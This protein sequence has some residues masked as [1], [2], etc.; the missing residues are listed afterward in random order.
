LEE[1]PP[2][3]IFIFATTEPH[4]I[5]STIHSRCQRFDFRRIAF[6]E[7]HDRLKRIASEEGIKI[8]EEALFSLTREAEGSLRDAQ[9]LLDQVIAFAG[10]EGINEKAVAGALGLMDRSVL[11]ELTEAV[12]KK[13]GKKCLN[14]VE[15]IYNFGY[16]LKK[17]A[18]DLLEQVRDLTVLKVTGEGGGAGLLELPESE[19]NRLE[20]LSGLIGLDRLQ[21]IFTVLTRGYEEVARSTSPRFSF[22]MA[23]LRAVHIEDVE[24]VPE[25]I[26]RLEL[27]K[28]KVGA[29]EGHGARSARTAHV[30]EGEGGKGAET[31]AVAEG[32]VRKSGPAEGRSKDAGRARKAG[33]EEGVGVEGP[34]SSEGPGTSTSGFMEHIR[35][36]NP[37][38]FKSLES[39]AVSLSPTGLT[40]NVI[41]EPGFL[42]VKKDLLESIASEYFKKRVPVK[43]KKEGAVRKESEG[44]APP[45]PDDTLLNDAKRIFGG[46][47]VEDRRRTN[48]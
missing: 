17:A 44:A 47:V 38:L 35:Q 24:S 18:A 14:I 21:M 19:A 8:E 15:K 26:S 30:A 27:L 29:A 13:D 5:P 22:E 28:Q 37:R 3:V 32:A 4:K 39:A 7:I 42:L 10:T 2:H 36:R 33:K 46:R 12:I 16:D 9:S 45:T 6:G 25:L 23:L 20:E 31:K 1:P 40:I 34:R 43:I 41:G 11:M 48:V